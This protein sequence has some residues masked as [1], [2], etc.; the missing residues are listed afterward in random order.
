M[1]DAKDID[2]PHEARLRSWNYFKKTWRA[3]SGKPAKAFYT[4]SKGLVGLIGPVVFF[5]VIFS[6]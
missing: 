2:S 3:S 4:Y 6:L 1:I 5:P